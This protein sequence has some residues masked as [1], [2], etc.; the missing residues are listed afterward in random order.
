M[1]RLLRLIDDGLYLVIDRLEFVANA[2]GGLANLLAARREANGSTDTG[3]D[4]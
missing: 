3:H 4:Q 2:C 1:I